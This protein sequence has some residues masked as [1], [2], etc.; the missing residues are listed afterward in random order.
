MSDADEWEAVLTI[1]AN[2]DVIAVTCRNK[3]TVAIDPRIF[4]CQL[5]TDGDHEFNP[6]IVGE[7]LS[8]YCIYCGAKDES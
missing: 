3:D 5:E 4:Q 8:E 2:A 6:D 7:G 1:L